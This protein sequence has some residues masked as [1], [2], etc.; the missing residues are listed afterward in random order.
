MLEL[1]KENLKLVL[2]VKLG[3]GGFWV[4]MCSLHGT[5]SPC[6]GVRSKFEQVKFCKLNILENRPWPLARK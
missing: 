4:E 3:I 5:A 1:N 6:G 2:S